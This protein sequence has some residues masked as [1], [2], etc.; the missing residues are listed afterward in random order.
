VRFVVVGR[1]AR[2]SA[3][4]SLEDLPGSSGRL[5]VLLGCVR[6]ALLV[7]HGVRRNAVVYLVLGGGPR[8][9][10]VLRVDGADVKFLRPDERS[11]AILARKV[12]AYEGSAPGFAEARPGVALAPGGLEVALAD[13]GA[14]AI[15]LLDRDGQDLR[16]AAGIEDRRAVFVLGDDSGLDVETRENLAQRGA[17]TLGVGPLGLHAEDVVAIV[18]NEVDRRARR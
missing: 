13:L 14:G 8:A 10:R 9:P 3:D 6:A 5:D 16:D 2:A 7:S 12:L 11:L 1:R 17:R 4:F 15:Y 18:A